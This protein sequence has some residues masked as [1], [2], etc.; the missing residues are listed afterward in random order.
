MA[1]KKDPITLSDYRIGKIHE[2]VAKHGRVEVIVA[3]E[4]ERSEL[5]G[6]VL[7]REESIPLPNSRESDSSR[8][9]VVIGVREEATA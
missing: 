4:V 1:K 6:F 5:K 9:F 3:N 8:L 2:G 7:E